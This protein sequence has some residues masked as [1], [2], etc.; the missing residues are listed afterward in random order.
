MTGMTAFWSLLLAT[1]RRAHGHGHSHCQ[2]S[3]GYVTR[4]H[5]CAV[6]T[7]TEAQ[8]PG[9]LKGPLPG[10]QCPGST[11]LL[12]GVTPVVLKGQLFHR[13][14]LA[15]ANHRAHPWDRTGAQTQLY[16]HGSPSPGGGGG[17]LPGVSHQQA[18]RGGGHGG[19]A[20]RPPAP[21]P[22]TQQ[23]WPHTPGSTGEAA[24]GPDGHRHTF[25][26]SSWFLRYKACFS[27]IHFMSL[28]AES[29]WR[30]RFATGLISKSAFKSQFSRT[31]DPTKGL[32]TQLLT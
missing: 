28:D 27:S 7:E 12:N 10:I 2:G 9:T 20:E 30:N 24:R 23:R 22:P 32:N 5:S 31:E 25:S 4:P 29:N 8:L 11:R 17:G 16:T 21:P 18:R 15:L 19:S 3:F 26:T 14:C 6:V 1:G 13:A